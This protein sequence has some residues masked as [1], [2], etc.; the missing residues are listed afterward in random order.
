[1]IKNYESCYKND[2]HV[3]ISYMR[4]KIENISELFLSNLF[5]MEHINFVNQRANELDSF[6]LFVFR[7]K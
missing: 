5:Q 1:M 4:F 3:Y 6:V 7:D 2:S